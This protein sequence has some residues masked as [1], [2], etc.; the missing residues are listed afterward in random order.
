MTQGSSSGP[1]GGSSNIGEELKADAGQ[2]GG[3][4]KQRA[5]EKGDEQVHAVAGQAKSVSS[6]LQSAAGELENGDTPGW[7]A[8]AFKGAADQMARL[9]DSL[10][11]KDSREL[12]HDL[13]DFARQNP[14]TFL[15]ASAAAGFAAA[16][17]LSIGQKAQHGAGGQFNDPGYFGSSTQAV[18]PTASSDSI[19]PA[20]TAGMQQARVVI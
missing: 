5:Q 14:T 13:N 8:S 19:E 2:L 18:V 17:L 3:K 4:A 11:G 9:A 7:L 10:E 20:G 16:R 12:V 6:A 1:S 15:A